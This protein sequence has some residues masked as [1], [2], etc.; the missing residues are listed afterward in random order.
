MWKIKHRHAGWVWKIVKCWHD[1]LPLIEFQFPSTLS[2]QLFLPHCVSLSFSV[3]LYLYLSHFVFKCRSPLDIIF[4]LFF[5]YWLLLCYFP[6]WWMVWVE[7]NWIEKNKKRRS[8]GK[9]IEFEI[10]TGVWV[11]Q[12]MDD[13]GGGGGFV[14]EHRILWILWG[15]IDGGEVFFNGWHDVM[16]NLSQND[17]LVEF[18]KLLNS[19][20]KCDCV[21]HV[22][23]R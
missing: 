6:L 15:K 18:F 19:R 2:T 4:I 9:K 21:F 1:I 8:G 5:F 3:Y 17:C 13:G 23:R 14:R 22:V 20:L 16:K 11:E 7:M 10:Q 12:W